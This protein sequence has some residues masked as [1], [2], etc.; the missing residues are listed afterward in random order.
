MTIKKQTRNRKDEREGGREGKLDK[1]W[2]KKK[3]EKT[4]ALAM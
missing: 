2:L 3:N 4:A 1:K